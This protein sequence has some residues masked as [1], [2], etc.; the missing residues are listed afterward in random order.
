[1]IKM[2]CR[3]G[4][5]AL[6][7]LIFVLLAQGSFAGSPLANFAGAWKNLNANTRDIVKMQIDVSGATITIH[8]WGAC[9]PTPCDWGTDGGVPYSQNVSMNP[10]GSTDIVSSV[11]RQKFGTVI[12]TI[13]PNGPTRLTVTCMTRFTDGSGRN[14]Y[15]TVETFDRDNSNGSQSLAAPVQVSQCGSSFSNYPRT[16]NVQWNAVAGA[17]SYTVEVDCQ[18]CCVGGKWCTDVGK[19]YI[20]APNLRGLTYTF[21]FAGAQAGRWRVWAVGNGNRQGQKSS[22]CNFVYTR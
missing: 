21:S 13:R 17:V 10:T 5:S 7:V 14:N 9:Q 15:A 11:F 8:V 1:M 20:V 22:W 19:T 3:T 16:T 6:P 4:K 18:G 2:L 12:L